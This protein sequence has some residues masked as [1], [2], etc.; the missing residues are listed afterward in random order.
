MN[1]YLNF[2]PKEKMKLFVPVFSLAAFIFATGMLPASGH[3]AEALTR[4]Q[5][6]SQDLSGPPVTWIG[7]IVESWRDGS[8]TCFRLQ[9]RFVE[10]GYRESGEEK[11][12]ACPFG[13][14][15]AGSFPIG[16]DLRVSGNLGD[17]M[18]RSIGGRVYAYP[19]IAG[20]SVELLPQRVPYHELRRHE[21]FPYP[22]D[23]LWH[24]W[25]YSHRC[26]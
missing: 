20:A 25:P 9:R 18:P 5:T 7:T 1:F 4:E 3:G 26:W 6:L 19:F 16:Q 8:D 21:L 13:F 10:N 12:I 22:C 23:P 24:R 17:A 15:D 14:Y 11:F 2:Q